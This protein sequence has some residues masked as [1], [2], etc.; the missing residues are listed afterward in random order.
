MSQLSTDRDRRLRRAQC[1]VQWCCPGTGG[2]G[3]GR[4]QYGGRYVTLRCS[5][6]RDLGGAL[7][8]PAEEVLQEAAA[9]GRAEW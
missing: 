8:I 3:V 1:G 2:S 4:R 5:E 9:A 6:R 7:R